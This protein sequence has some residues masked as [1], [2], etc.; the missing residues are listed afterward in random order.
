MY[1]FLTLSYTCAA[2][3]LVGV[4][5]KARIGLNLSFLVASNNCNIGSVN[6]AVF[7]VPVCAEASTSLPSKIN[8]IAF[9]CIGDGSV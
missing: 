6:P 9:F 1:Q 8:G 4:K 5:T 3:S 7:P 2:N